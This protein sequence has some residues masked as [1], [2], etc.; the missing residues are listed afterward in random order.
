M[1]CF[2][3]VAQ[4]HDGFVKCVS[5]DRLCKSVVFASLVFL[6]FSLEVISSAFVVPLA[7]VLIVEAFVC[8][9]LF[10]VMKLV[11]CVGCCY[12]FGVLL[13]HCV[14]AIGLFLNEE[15]CLFHHKSCVLIWNVLFL[16]LF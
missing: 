13:H 8:C 10:C 6:L 16:L 7:A 9:F 2:Y 15:L 5:S 14:A 11:F 4:R 1:L 12:W 3:F